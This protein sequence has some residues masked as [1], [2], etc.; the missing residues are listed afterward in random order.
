MNKIEQPAKNPPT[1]EG[2]DVVASDEQE[3]SN[4]ALESVSGGVKRTGPGTQTEDDIYVG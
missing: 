3:L 2:E 1:D 4:D